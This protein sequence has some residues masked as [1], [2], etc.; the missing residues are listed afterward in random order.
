M[1]HNKFLPLYLLFL[2]VHLSCDRPKCTNNNPVFEENTADSKIYKD[3]LVKQLS[4]VDQ[5]QL[6]YWL[7]D[8]ENVN[9]DEYLYFYIQ[10]DGLCASLHLKMEH[11]QKLENVRDKKGSGRFNAEFTNLKFDIKQDSTSTQFV[12]NTFDRIID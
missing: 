2:L 9:G 1:R 10:G 3:E 7:Q 8:Y 5:T 4:L 6:T 12:Y 11:W